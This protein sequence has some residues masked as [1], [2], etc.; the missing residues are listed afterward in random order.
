MPEETNI[1]QSQIIFK[2][3]GTKVHKQSELG[4]EVSKKRNLCLPVGLDANHITKGP[5]KRYNLIESVFRPQQI[6]LKQ[7][8]V[9]FLRYLIGNSMLNPL[10]ITI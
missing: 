2:Q 10:W 5:R 7:C 8:F 4:K 1:C 3:C 6:W 9:S